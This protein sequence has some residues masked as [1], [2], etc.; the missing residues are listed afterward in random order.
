MGGTSAWA[1]EDP[2]GPKFS[3]PLQTKDIEISGRPTTNEVKQSF[4]L[5]NGFRLSLLLLKS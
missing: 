4:P 1:K 3:K 5:F 2:A